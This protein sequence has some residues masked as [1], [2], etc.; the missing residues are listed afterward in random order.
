MRL[1]SSVLTRREL[2]HSGSGLDLNW[3]M[4]RDRHPGM[5]QYWSDLTTTLVKLEGNVVWQAFQEVA[6]SWGGNEGI[7]IGQGIRFQPFSAYLGPWGI[8]SG[9]FSCFGGEP[10]GPLVFTLL[11]PYSPSVAC[12]AVY[13]ISPSCAAW[14]EGKKHVQS[15]IVSLPQ[16]L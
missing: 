5:P 6:G 10:P 4:F 2:Q 15:G 13:L 16:I 9:S 8:G 14:A 12:C 1:K 11:Y 3:F 7:H